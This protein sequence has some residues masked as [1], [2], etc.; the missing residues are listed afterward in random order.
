MK[1]SGDA[2]VC[3]L[4]AQ[5][6]GGKGLIGSHEQVYNSKQKLRGTFDS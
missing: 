6:G 4:V 3:T 2:I 1:S 5:R